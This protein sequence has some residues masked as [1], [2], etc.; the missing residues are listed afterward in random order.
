MRRL[1]PDDTLR[2]W[3]FDVQTVQSSQ[4]SQIDI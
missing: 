2:K 4:N 1:M 3:N